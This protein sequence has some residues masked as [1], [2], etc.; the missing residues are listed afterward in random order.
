MARKLRLEV[1]KPKRKVKVSKEEAVPLLLRMGGH[2]AAMGGVISFVV[3]STIIG[4][5]S[6][7]DVKQKISNRIGQGKYVELRMRK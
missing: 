3:S 7:F 2:F 1:Y 5:K 4:V 6:F